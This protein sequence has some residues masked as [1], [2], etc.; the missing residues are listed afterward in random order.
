MIDSMFLQEIK[1]S[2]V[3]KRR[4]C[5]SCKMCCE[6]K[7]IDPEKIN[8][9][10]AKLIDPF[11]RNEDFEI[12]KSGCCV[13]LCCMKKQVI[14]KKNKQC[15]DDLWFRSDENHCADGK[16]GVNLVTKKKSENDEECIEMVT[17]Q[18]DANK[19]EMGNELRKK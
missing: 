4:C 1:N 19:R 18:K 10:V 14:V 13:S 9:F 5:R 3:Y 17:I 11:K 2:E 12:V 7:I 16:C 8:P 15:D 6:P